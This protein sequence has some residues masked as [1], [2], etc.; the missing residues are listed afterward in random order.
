VQCDVSREESLRRFRRRIADPTR[1]NPTDVELA[2]MLETG[3]LAYDLYEPLDLP[4][5]VLAATPPTS[6][7]RCSMLAWRTWWRR[8][9]R[10]A[11]ALENLGPTGGH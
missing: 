8:S 3:T 1:Q 2:G 7:R 11:S 6:Q 4:C 9:G 5:P 10:T